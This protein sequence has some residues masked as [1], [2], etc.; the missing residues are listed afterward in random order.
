MSLQWPHLDERTRRLFGA[1]EARELGD[2]GLSLV[3]GVCRLSRATI[4]KGLQELDEPPLPASRVRRAGRGR[5]Q[6]EVRNAEFVECLDALVDPW[7]R[8]DPESPLP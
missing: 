6:I 5:P 7:S 4:T 1:S 3:S 2:G 8:G